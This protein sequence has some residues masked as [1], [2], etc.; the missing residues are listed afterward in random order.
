MEDFFLNHGPYLSYLAII[1]FLILT[2]AGMPIPE[3]VAI[4][5]AGYL[6]SPAQE[7]L[8]P[9]L[10]FSACL[11]GA[12]LGDLLVYCIGR[13]VG[14]SFFRRHPR[15]AHLLHEER[16]Q[17][18]EELIRRHGM[19][20]FLLAR[21]MVGVRAPLYLAAG[22][23]KLSWKRFLC[24][25]AVCATIVVSVAFWL[26]YFFGK[27]VHNWLRH[28]QWTVTAV[29]LVIAGIVGILFLFHRR[30]RDSA[31]PPTEEDHAEEGHDVVRD[32]PSLSHDDPA[33]DDHADAS[34][35]VA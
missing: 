24:V 26:S 13:F 16:E 14:H 27:D 21:F 33:K 28:S 30:R 7:V 11:I 5:T 31:G 8:D 23:L 20:I 32:P 22:A 12:L 19:K 25:N 2:G 3:E 9:T 17:Q 15:F 35:I 29:V 34:R 1:A 10:A 6:S 18:M 4:I